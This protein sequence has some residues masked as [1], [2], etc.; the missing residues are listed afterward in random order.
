VLALAPLAALSTPRPGPPS[1]PNPEPRTREAGELIDGG[2]SSR[3]VACGEQRFAPVES[4][5]GAGR[6]VCIQ[7]IER[8]AE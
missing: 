5:I 3:H 8:A 4:Q 7:P 1:T 6:I 2:G